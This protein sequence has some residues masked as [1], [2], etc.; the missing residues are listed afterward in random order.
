MCS[1]FSKAGTGVGT[2]V[3]GVGSAGS[4]GIKGCGVAVGVGVIEGVGEGVALARGVGVTAGVALAAGSVGGG[5]KEGGSVETSRAVAVVS[6]EEG[7]V[8]SATATLVGA[9][10]RSTVQPV[11]AKSV[12]QTTFSHPR[13]RHTR[14]GSI[15]WR[16][17]TFPAGTG[18]LRTDQV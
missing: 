5:V 1:G 8:V 6:G 2:A 4:R 15:V 3:A 14:R 13:F 11:N 12:R 17:Y 10:G 7:V 9:S 16:L 18:V